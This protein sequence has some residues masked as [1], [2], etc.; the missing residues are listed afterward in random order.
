MDQDRPGPL[1]VR[2]GLSSLPIEPKKLQAATQFVALLRKHL[3][4]QDTII[5]VAHLAARNVADADM[6]E[7]NAIDL[8]SYGAIELVIY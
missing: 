6:D 5:H 7:L 1:N 3:I 8:L 4:C 2:G